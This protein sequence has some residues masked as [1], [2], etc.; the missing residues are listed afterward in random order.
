MPFDY[1]LNKKAKSVV[2]ACLIGSILPSS[3]CPV[4]NVVSDCSEADHP[5]NSCLKSYFWS[6]PTSNPSC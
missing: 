6:D 4:H 2:R 3:Y 5:T 1:D